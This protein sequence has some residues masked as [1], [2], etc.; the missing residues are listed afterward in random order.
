MQ[1]LFLNT[2][3]Q[4]DLCCALHNYNTTAHACTLAMRITLPLQTS[5]LSPQKAHTPSQQG[6]SSRASAG[7]AASTVTS[8]ATAA[9]LSRRLLPVPAASTALPGQPL[10][11]PQCELEFPQ[12]ELG[13]DLSN[14][15]VVFNGTG[16]MYLSAGVA[17]VLLLCGAG[18][19]S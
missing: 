3:T 6:Q 11:F 15:I 5:T 10:A 19:W 9:H 8:S 13:L 12:A 16:A 1:L 14:F 4:A 7:S 17:G 2:P 18:C